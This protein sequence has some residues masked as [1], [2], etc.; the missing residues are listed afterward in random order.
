MGENNYKL[1]L[2]KGV[3]AGNFQAVTLYAASTAA[4]VDMPGQSIPSIN[5]QSESDSNG[6]GSID[7][8]FGPEL[9]ASTFEPNYIGT[10]DEKGYFPIIRLYSPGQSYFDKTG[11][12]DDVIRL[13]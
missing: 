8:Y 7:L 3:P 9:P 1:R 4:G 10:N 11:R 13:N 5:S 12:P 2:P 6:D